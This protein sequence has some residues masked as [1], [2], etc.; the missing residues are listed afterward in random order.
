MYLS[1]ALANRFYGTQNQIA[2]V[3]GRCASATRTNSGWPGRV[4][5]LREA[6]MLSNAVNN[7]GLPGSTL[8][9]SCNGTAAPMPEDEYRANP[10]SIPSA[11]ADGI[12]R[13]VLQQRAERDAVDDKFQQTRVWRSN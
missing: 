9:M 3:P 13:R 12:P 11:G 7:N 10:S 2:F 4:S 8:Q 6:G 5:E 1:P